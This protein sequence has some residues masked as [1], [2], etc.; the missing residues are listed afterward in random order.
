M[1]PAVDG[2]KI[3]ENDNQA[4]KHFYVY[5]YNFQQLADDSN[6]LWPSHYYQKF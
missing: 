3:F 4:S 5:H 2:I 6:I 1:P